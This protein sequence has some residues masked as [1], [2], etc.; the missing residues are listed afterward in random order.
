MAG[1]RS[2][3]ERFWKLANNNQTEVQIPFEQ[4]SDFYG[5]STKKPLIDHKEGNGKFVKPKL[6][7][8][9]RIERA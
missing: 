6:I 3:E 2:G 7:L 4:S 8:R 9:M 1:R 5:E